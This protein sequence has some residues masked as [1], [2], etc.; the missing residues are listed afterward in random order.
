MLGRRCFKGMSASIAR[1]T[2]LMKSGLEWRNP[3]RGSIGRNTVRE[4]ARCGSETNRNPRS[5]FGLVWMV[6]CTHPTK[7]QPG[8]LSRR[9]GP[10][11]SLGDRAGEGR[12]EF[13][14]WL[15]VKSA[16]VRSRKPCGVR[17]RDK[18]TKR[19]P[20]WAEPE[21]WTHQVSDSVPICCVIT[22]CG[23]GQWK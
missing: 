6:G 10:T 15:A 3:G 14:P 1:D 20:P 2:G 4:L 7:K 12:F 19:T 13:D 22:F 5:R 18:S 11:M 9:A 23:L 17:M 8:L 16:R 21:K